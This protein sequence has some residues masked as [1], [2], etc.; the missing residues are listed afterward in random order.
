M[1]LERYIGFQLRVH[2]TKRETAMQAHEHLF[3]PPLNTTQ[4]GQGAAPSPHALHT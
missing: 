4:A 1:L 3:L 2:T